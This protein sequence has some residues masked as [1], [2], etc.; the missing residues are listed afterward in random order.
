[1]TPCTAIALFVAV[2]LL[3]SISTSVYAD[4]G[5][6]YYAGFR[7][8]GSDGVP[9]SGAVGIVV[10]N[11]ACYECGS[12]PTAPLAAQVS[13]SDGVIGVNLPVGCYTMQIVRPGGGI[14]L[15]FDFY[16]PQ[17]ATMTVRLSEDSSTIQKELQ[18]NP[19]NL[20]DYITNSTSGLVGPGN[21]SANGTSGSLPNG[22]SA[23]LYTTA[24][25]QNKPIY[26][27]SYAS[28]PPILFGLALLAI[29]LESASQ[30]ARKKK[31]KPESSESA[32]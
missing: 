22:T 8:L 1:L 7:I 6:S 19:I 3:S 4:S 10:L 16:T 25:T 13:D 21:G 12:L 20:G 17:N 23:G 9:V 30:V 29:A 5:G 18:Q 28:P 26:V 31:A 15:E 27:L 24:P 32:R 2:L 14:Y 11:A